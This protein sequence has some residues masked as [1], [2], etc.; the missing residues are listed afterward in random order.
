MTDLFLGGPFHIMTGCSINDQ[1]EARI[2][3]FEWPHLSL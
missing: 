2:A 1:I 3:Y